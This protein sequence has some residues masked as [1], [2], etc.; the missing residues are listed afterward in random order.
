MKDIK[1]C[2]FALLSAGLF[3]ACSDDDDVTNPNEGIVINVDVTG[4]IDG[5]DYVD[6]GLPSGVLWA[7]EDV[8]ATTASGKTSC[9]FSWGETSPKEVYDFTTYTYATPDSLYTK[10]VVNPDC[11]ATKTADNI[12]TLFS[13]DDTANRIWGGRWFMPSADDLRELVNYCTFDYVYDKDSLCYVTGTSKVNGKKIYFPMVGLMYEDKLTFE[14]QGLFVMS[15]D[16]GEQDRYA[17]GFTANFQENE[18]TKKLELHAGM[19]MRLRI[20]GFCVRPCIP[21]TATPKAVDLGLPSGTKWA[22]INLGA[23]GPQYQGYLFAWGETVTK[24]P[25]DYTNYAFGKPDAFTKYWTNGEGA[26]NKTVLETSEDAARKVWGEKWQMPSEEDFDELMK[27]C[28]FEPETIGTLKVVKVTGPNGNSIIL[29]CSG[30][31]WQENLEYFNQRGFY[32]CTKLDPED[33][34][35]GR[36]LFITGKGTAQ[37]GAKFNR[38]SGRTIRPVKK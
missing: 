36:G 30:T 1:F 37:W 24:F 17:R 16:L 31:I 23:R 19:K 32:W 25:Y 11:S 20:Q 27:E 12:L 2:L 9:F 22:D 21:A 8:K 15:S 28:Q 34:I 38:G 35:Y 29:P 7:T 13:S 10:Y 5:H 3:T 26:D 6:L 33:D 4:E 18:E 14:N